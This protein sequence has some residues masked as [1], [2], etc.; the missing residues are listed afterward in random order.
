MADAPKLELLRDS[1]LAVE[2]TGDQC[3]V[4]GEL[5]AF[6]DPADCEVFADLSPLFAASDRCTDT[7]SSR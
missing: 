6:R 2:L 5:I 1:A 4:L 7:D 3:A